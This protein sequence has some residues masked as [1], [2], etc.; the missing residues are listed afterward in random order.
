MLPALSLG[1]NASMDLYGGKATLLEGIGAE[2]G[3]SLTEKITIFDGGRYSTKKAINKLTSEATRQ[4]A[5]A[6]LYTVLGSVDAAYYDCLKARASLDAAET[7]ME[8]AALALEIAEIR[9]QSR[10]I[11]Q[12]DYLKALAD[13]E[14]AETSRIQARRALTLAETKLRAITGLSALPEIEGVDFTGYEALIQKMSALNA[15]GLDSL[16]GQLWQTAAKKNPGLIKAGIGIQQAEK[17]VAMAKKD[18]VP[19]ISASFSTGLSYSLRD[20]LSYPGSISLS[21]TIPLD[22]WVTA[23]NV[24]KTK[25]AQG[26]SVL[27]YQSVEENLAISVQ[28]ALL[29]A[30]YQAAAVLS[31]RRAWEYNSRHYDQTLELYRLSQSSLSNLSDAAAALGSS[32]TSLI[33]ARYGFLQTLSTL[34]GLCCFEQEDEFTTLVL[35]GT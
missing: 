32:T 29:D 22:Y 23:A 15:A 21:G 5:L 19:S 17:N 26:E 8:S 2:A 34:R 20:G 3:A 25:N 6:Q 13:K 24:Q 14:S 18:Y 27:A 16:Y 7:S 12:G 9:L 35:G 4:D 28:S 10:V 33:N 30:T 1:G 31:A 11:S